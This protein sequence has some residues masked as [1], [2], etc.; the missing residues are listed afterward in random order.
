[1]EIQLALGIEPWSSK[2]TKFY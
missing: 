2:T 1:M